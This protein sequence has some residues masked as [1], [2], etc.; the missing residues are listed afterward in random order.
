V[1]WIAKTL[2]AVVAAVF[3]CAGVGAAWLWFYTADLPPA[4][5]LA[6][7]APAAEAQ[8]SLPEC[9][10]TQVSVL[11]LPAQQLGRYTLAALIAAEGEP[12]SRSPYIST[13]VALHHE[14]HTTP[15][16]WQL[17]RQMMCVKRT[18]LR[19]RFEELRLAHAI[20]RGFDSR[21][22]LTI[23]LNRAYL[24]KDVYGI[25]SGAHKYFGKHASDLSLEETAWLVGLIR[26]PTWLAAHPERAMQRRNNVLDEM[27]RKGS[28]TTG[29]AETAKA[30]PVAFHL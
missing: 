6:A 3:T 25:G 7:F 26:R 20:Q 5:Q 2:G 21:Q 17:A 16:S 18:G 8:V 9:D 27:V 22:L 12:D 24:G 29:E 14:P 30:T 13:F 10:G 11:A 1:K 23:Y 19:R 28:I 15:Y 4:S